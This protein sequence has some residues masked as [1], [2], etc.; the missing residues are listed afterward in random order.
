M[1]ALN[2]IYHDFHPSVV[3][4]RLGMAESYLNAWLRV[5][6]GL[7]MLAAIPLA[8]FIRGIR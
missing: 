1:T 6:Q 2:V 7:A 4:G 8:L 5:W 3:A